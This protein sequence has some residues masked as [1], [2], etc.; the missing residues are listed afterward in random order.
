MLQIAIVFCVVLFFALASSD[1]LVS[2]I[3]SDELDNMG[4][5]AKHK[6]DESQLQ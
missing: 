1:L 2:N 3:N 6:D 4:V 5:E